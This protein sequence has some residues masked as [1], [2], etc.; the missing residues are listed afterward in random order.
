[1]LHILLL[2]AVTVGHAHMTLGGGISSVTVCE[3]NACCWG[4]GGGGCLRI[5]VY[6]IGYLHLVGNLWSV[7][8]FHL[9]SN[10]TT[11]E[12]ILGMRPDIVYFVPTPQ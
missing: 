7:C 12:Y 11:D 1:M 4:G 9:Y 6:G 3:E 5:S 10:C 2:H 8:P